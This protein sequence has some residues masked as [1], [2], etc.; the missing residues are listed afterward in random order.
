M[1]NEVKDIIDNGS[2]ATDVIN[3]A[4]PEVDKDYLG[5]TI[6]KEVL[7]KEKDKYKQRI[8]EKETEINTYKEQ[9]SQFEGLNEKLSQVNSELS[10][11]KQIMLNNKLVEAGIVDVDAFCKLNDL[12]SVEFENGQ[13]KIQEIIELAK[14][15]QAYLFKQEKPKNI[16]HLN[17]EPTNSAPVF[18]IDKMSAHDIRKNFTKLKELGLI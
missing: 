5:E 17:V 13:P 16:G 2:S 1:E 7:I 8:A 14:E 4:Q 3:P 10:A 11:F 12:S 9:I 18:D 15:K 6:T